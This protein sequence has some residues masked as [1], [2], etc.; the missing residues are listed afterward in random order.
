MHISV[1]HRTGD[2]N[3]VLRK[4]DNYF[5]QNPLVWLASKE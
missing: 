3:H 4:T 1:V 2:V 5:A